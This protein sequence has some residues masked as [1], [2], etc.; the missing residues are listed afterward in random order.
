MKFAIAIEN[1]KKS[2]EL[3]EKFFEK[4]RF[5]P[6]Y[7][8][9]VFTVEELKEQEKEIKELKRKVEKKL[10]DEKV[11]GEFII[12]KGDP[13]ARVGKLI[14]EREIEIFITGYEHSVF[15]TT[16]FEEIA[17]ETDIPILVLR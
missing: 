8:L 16:F 1:T 14:E 11:K 7:T 6:R 3:F 5:C 17:R 9:D 2:W 12:E 13:A 15:S 4:M 10:K